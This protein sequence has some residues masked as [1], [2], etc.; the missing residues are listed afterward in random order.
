MILGDSRSVANDLRRD[1]F[2]FFRFGGGS[3]ASAGMILLSTHTLT[4]TA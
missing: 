1:P 3:D 4:C 2:F